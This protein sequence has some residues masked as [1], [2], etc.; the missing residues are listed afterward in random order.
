MENKI[1]EIIRIKQKLTKQETKQ[2]IFSWLI[3]QKYKSLQVRLRKSQ[4]RHTDTID[5]ET[6]VLATI[7]EDVK[8]QE[9][10]MDNFIQIHLIIGHLNNF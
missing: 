1:E 3:K 9:N 5:N 8:L 2:T 6:G 4:G 7:R 10:S